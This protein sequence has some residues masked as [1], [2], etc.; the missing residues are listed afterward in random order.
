MGAQGL[1]CVPSGRNGT[2][3]HRPGHVAVQQNMR[4]RRGVLE[5]LGDL[6]SEREVEAI[7]GGLHLRAEGQGLARGQ[8]PMARAVEARRQLHVVPERRRLRGNREGGIG[9]R[10]GDARQPQPRGQGTRHHAQAGPAREAMEPHAD[11]VLGGVV[12]E[13]HRHP[14]RRLAHGRV[15]QPLAQVRRRGRRRDEEVG[16]VDGR[17]GRP[18]DRKGRRREELE[19]AALR[20]RAEVDGPAPG[21][22]EEDGDVPVEPRLRCRQAVRLRALELHAAAP[23]DGADDLV[24]LHRERQRHGRLG[25][26]LAGDAGDD[27][28]LALGERRDADP[29]VDPE[30]LLIRFDRPL[31]ERKLTRREH[32]SPR[33]GAAGRPAFE[34][35]KRI[36]AFHRVAGV[37]QSVASSLGIWRGRGYLQSST[38]FFVGL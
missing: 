3:P 25:L 20:G 5:R 11:R 4:R 16:R 32:H 37:G 6:L 18:A 29:F 1:R 8:R 10:E 28:E 38:S 22:R 36:V 33:P 9:R 19:V 15:A 24:E 17:V 35:T 13:A 2:D 31:D 14:Q 34:Q 21:A 30:S 27:P 7:K 12:L 23:G 26:L